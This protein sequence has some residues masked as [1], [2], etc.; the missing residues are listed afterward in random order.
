MP[1]LS[2]SAAVEAEV[3]PASAVVSAV[4][5]PS[6]VAA[7]V[8]VREC[9]FHGAEWAAFGPEQ[10]QLLGLGGVTF[11]WLQS[12]VPDTVSGLPITAA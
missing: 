3:V 9:S 8:A 5:E 12:D 4:G 11:A 2:G 7:S 6:E 1:K 10:S